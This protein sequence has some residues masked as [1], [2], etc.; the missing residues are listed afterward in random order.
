MGFAGAIWRKHLRKSRN[1]RKLGDRKK[2]GG[3]QVDVGVGMGQELGSQRE[4]I[5]EKFLI[6]GMAHDV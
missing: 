4:V 1:C 6:V 5:S 3:E 2:M